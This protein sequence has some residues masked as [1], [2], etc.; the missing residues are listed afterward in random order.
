MKNEILSDGMMGKCR[1][2]EAIL[3]NFCQMSHVVWNW[4][5]YIKVPRELY[6]FQFYI[7]KQ[8]VALWES[9]IILTDFNS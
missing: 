7:F 3:Q 6:C 2:R 8:G 9:S 1:G 4:S 5:L